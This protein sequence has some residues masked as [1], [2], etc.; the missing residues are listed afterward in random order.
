MISRNARGIFGTIGTREAYWWLVGMREAYWWLVGMRE[1]CCLVGTREAY[2][3]LV[4]TREAYLEQSESA[5]LEEGKS[6]FE[7]HL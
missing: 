3:C 2:C 4:G 7:R 1:D 6:G 5:K